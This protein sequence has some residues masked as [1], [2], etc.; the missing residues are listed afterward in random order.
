MK[1]LVPIVLA[2]FLAA[3]G[4]AAAWG[5]FGHKVIALIAY[6]HLTPQARGR[7]DAL[8]ASDAD[9]LTTPDFPSRATWA[10]R[11]AKIH[12]E[13]A[14]WHFMDQ[15]IDQPDV[16]AACFGF[17]PL[18]AGQ[19]A[20]AGPA[21][22]CVID[23]IDQF[24]AELRDPATAPAERLLALKF[25]IHFVGDLHQ[26]LHVADHHDR[27][28]NCVKLSPSPDGDVT[29]LHLFWDITAPQALGATPEAVAAMLDA[30]ATPQQIAAWERGDA[31]SWA[32]E[33]FDLGRR[34]AYDLPTRPT[35]ADQNA[36]VA[37]T[38]AYEATA[39]AD[40][41]QRL[42]IAGVRLAAVLNTDLGRIAG[43]AS[44]AG[45]KPTGP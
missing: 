18:A 44:G 3:A 25:L 35:C 39:E 42:E 26:P 32:A 23:K 27:G 8:L 28:G 5:D 33:S 16:A 43:G 4:P 10:D 20:S 41:A 9:T 11:Y 13:T 24:S 31:R 38:P 40:T 36:A 29:N 30:K 19:V 1:A 37:L 22:D 15:E 14:A 45:P 6:R 12:R 2:L 7:L 17:P 34:D 21:Q